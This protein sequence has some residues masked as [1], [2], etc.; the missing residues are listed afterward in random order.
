METKQYKNKEMKKMKQTKKATIEKPY[1]VS[2]KI[3]EDMH[4]NT[5]KNIDMWLSEK[6]LDTM[7]NIIDAN[8]IDKDVIRSY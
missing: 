1:F 7:Q 2:L 5:F 6:D 3:C 8:K 4:G